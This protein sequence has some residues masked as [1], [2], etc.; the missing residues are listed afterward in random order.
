M[1]K[2]DFFSI[3]IKLFGLYSIIISLFS[4]LP[5]NLSWLVNSFDLLT[6]IWVAISFVVSFGLIWLLILNSEKVVDL[7]KLDKGFKDD[8]ID[9]G[10]LSSMEIVKIGSFIIG[11]ILFLD[12]LPPFLSQTYFAFK[13]SINHTNLSIHDDYYWLIN[14]INLVIGYLLITNYDWVAKRLKHS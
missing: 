10:N 14:G 11:G 5:S 12:N 1:S 8:R 3:V 7:L 6:G 9:F 2:R 13:E 4:I